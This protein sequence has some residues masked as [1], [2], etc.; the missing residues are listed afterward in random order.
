MSVTIPKACVM[1]YPV[2]HSRSPMLHGYWLKTLGIPGFYEAAEVTEQDFPDFLRNLRT[3]GYVGG[4]ITV[5]H[6]EAAFRSVDHADAAARAIGAVNTV[7]HEGDRLVGG[8]TDA[9]GFIAHLDASVPH[10][11]ESADRAVVLGAGGTA[12]AI[13]YAL[14]DRGLA[15]ALVNRTIARARDLAIHFAMRASA[16]GFDE[17]PQLLADADIL[18]NATSLGMAG[19]PRLDIDLVRLKPATIVYDVVYVPLET[20]LLKAARR[21]GHRTV[22]GLGMLLHQAVPGFARWFGATPAVTPEL[23]ALIESDIKAKA[24]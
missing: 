13:V 12:R 24:A 17:L 4:N 10:W 1:G 2:A 19:K 7:W 6:K 16:H 3:H 8:N 5:P 23:R 11:N 14:L 18:V 9:F 21:H 22:D 20:E 15:V